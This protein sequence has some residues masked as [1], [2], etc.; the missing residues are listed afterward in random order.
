MKYLLA[1]GVDGL[2]YKGILLKTIVFTETT[3]KVQ[4]N[5]ILK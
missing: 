4:P 2:S 1:F 5:M 3:A